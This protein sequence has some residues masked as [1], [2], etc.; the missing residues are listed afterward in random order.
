M[1]PWFSTHIRILI[2]LHASK[3]AVP[4]AVHAFGLRVELPLTKHN[5]NLPLQDHLQR[6]DIWLLTSLVK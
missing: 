5:F 3:P 4:L 6:R 2:G 1:T